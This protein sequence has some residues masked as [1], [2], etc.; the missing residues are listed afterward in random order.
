VEFCP[1]EKVDEEEGLLGRGIAGFEEFCPKVKLGT[2]VGVLRVLELLV[3]C[4]KLNILL[5][6]ELGAPPKENDDDVGVGALNT[7]V[8][9]VV[10]VLVEVLV[11]KLNTDAGVDELGVVEEGAVLNPK[12]AVELLL[13]P[14]LKVE[15]GVV[16]GLA[17]PKLNPIFPLFKVLVVFPDG[18][19]VLFVF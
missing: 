14:K 6:V 11:P 13:V 15:A 16:V 12:L 9:G 17:V 10:E 19:D 5:V 1:K 4:G 7:E 2:A 18:V 3:D 8:A